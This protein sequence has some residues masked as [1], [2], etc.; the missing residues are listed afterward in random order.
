[1]AF[2]RLNNI[3]FWLLPPSLIL[4][5][6]SSFVESGVGTGWTV[7]DRHLY[8][9]NYM[10]SLYAMLRNPQFI[11]LKII[12]ITENYSIKLSLLVK[13][14]S[15]ILLY[16]IYYGLTIRN[17]IK[18]WGQSAWLLILILARNGKKK[19]M[20]FLCLINFYERK[21]ELIKFMYINHQRLNVEQSENTKFKYDHSKNINKSKLYYSKEEFYHWLVGFTDGDGCFSIT[22]QRSK[23]GILKWGLFFKIEQS[24][25]NLRA[26]YF[27]K[28]N[29]GY[30]SVQVESKTT[31]ADFR[32]RDKHVI[33]KIIFPI[34][35][36]YPLLTRKIFDYLKF[37]KAY[38]IITDLNITNEDKDRLLLE[39]KNQKIPEDYISPV[40][41]KI[42]YQ[43]KDT[44]SA[45]HIISKYWLV[46][47][48]E[49]EGSFY[50]VN[51]S[52]K[53]LVHAFEITQ[54][55]DFIVLQGISFILGISVTSK[56][57]HWTIV[58]TNSR[59]V[60]NIIDYYKNTMKGM[61]ALEYRIWAKSFTKYRGN[62][63]ELN[64]VR[65]L[66]RKIRLI[67]LDKN[68]C[69]KSEETEK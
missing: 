48:T 25:Y 66:I 58:T 54:K 45:K 38:S 57:T 26:L 39:L 33:N 68:C 3:S 69:I 53:R 41:K 10:N 8:N 51:K 47:F 23:S 42:N 21:K 62:Y 6:S 12:N 9:N 59:A 50:V 28:K 16:Y 2:P 44:N 34:F 14:F 15:V 55:L 22:C 13:K 49:A 43:V 65:N 52:E 19:N 61:K 32:I 24:S 60:N 1:M 63:N 11:I 31:N 37:K 18:G 30:G 36:K 29:L 17:I 40:W 27:I 64:K 7:K 56:K 67:R 20:N 35:D 46:G 5:L 4:L